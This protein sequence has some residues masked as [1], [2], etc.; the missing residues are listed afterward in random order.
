MQA[1]SSYSKAFLLLLALFWTESCDCES[2]SSPDAGPQAIELGTGGVAFEAL[3]EDQELLLVNGIQGGFHFVVH[4][5]MRGM[6][7]G[8]PASPGALGNPQTR[9]SIYREDGT[10]IDSMAPPYRLGFREADDGWLEM[11]SGRILQ[12]SQVLV[13]EGI[14][15]GLYAEKVRLVVEIRDVEG[16]EAMDEIWVRP[17]R[18]TNPPSDAGPNELADAGP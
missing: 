6:L 10:R 5:R 8:T 13:L 7:G 9:F 12:L 3:S 1:I 11:S 15:P 16:V 2:K 14:L 4:A 18:D 17:L